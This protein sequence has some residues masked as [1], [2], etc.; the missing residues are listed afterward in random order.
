M[1]RLLIA[2]VLALV[3]TPVLAA[4]TLV[5][6][7]GGGVTMDLLLVKGGTFTQGSP[8]AE[9][10]RGGD[11]TQRKVVLTRDYYLGKFPVTRGQFARFAKD[12]NYK[13]EAERGTSGG[14]GWD[15]EK[16][17][18]KKEY[19][20][21][22]PGFEQTDDHPVVIVTYDD[23]KAFCAWLTKKA[24]R[25][26][27]LPT[28]AQWEHACRA[29]TATAW[30][31]GD[32]PENAGEIA[33][34]RSNAGKGTQP[35]GKKKANAWGLCDMSGN[36][37]EWCRDW[38]GPYKE[39]PVENPEEKNDKLS[40]PPRRVLRG[41]SW[42]REAK[43]TRSAARSRSTPGTRNADN[44]FRVAIVKPP[45]E[46]EDQPAAGASDGP[47]LA[48]IDPPFALVEIACFIVFAAVAV[49][50]VIYLVKTLAARGGLGAPMGTAPPPPFGRDDV[51]TRLG[52]D[53]FWLDLPGVARGSQVRYRCRVAGEDRSGS[54]DYEPG[55]QG[56][57]VYT[58]G[59]PNAVEIIDVMHPTGGSILPPLQ[60][61]PTTQPPVIVTP[62]H[63]HR[64]PPR[65][66]AP[67]PVSHPPAY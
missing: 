65:P 58:G 9:P 60:S 13:T 11:E 7:L 24:G 20:W 44:G 27:S 4:D 5:L 29:G 21:R 66:V 14:F 26:V 1:S 48:M 42:L 59:R 2:S 54:I 30:Y 19:T 36:V 47:P 22:N 52:D 34:Y 17:T 6:D 28:E 64:P 3:A 23:A 31:D 56:Q 35:V 55:P 57:F 8:M 40:D 45:V 12:A 41:G 15:G 18:Q 62:P 49:V 50:V 25:E 16:L 33:W 32:D 39:G 53:G 10:G 61:W 46:K 43:W 51:R 67:P 37:F 63:V 38:Y